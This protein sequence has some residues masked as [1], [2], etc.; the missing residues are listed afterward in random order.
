MNPLGR[1]LTAASRGADDLRATTW[2][3][4]SLDDWAQMFTDPASV[5]GSRVLET[6]QGQPAE[7]SDGS[8]A[9]MV[10]VAYRR[11]GVVFAVM[12]V[13]MKL[14]SEARFQFQQMNGGKPGDL[15]GTP[16]LAILERPWPKA[17]TGDLLSRMLQDADLA[18]NSYIVRRPRFL[19]R[20][21]PDWCAL[22]LGSTERPDIDP[23]A[24]D[25]ELVGLMYVPGGFDSD[26]EPDFFLPEE[27][28][29]FA[30]IPD[31]LAHYRGMSWIT[32]IIRE[33][34]ADGAA[35][36][37]KLKFFENG[38]TPNLVVSLD[39]KIDA[40]KFKDWVR[41]F[42][43]KHEGVRNAY[44]TL[45]LGAGAT[46]VPVGKDL[47]QLEFKVT[48]GAGETRIAAA[49]GVPPVI[50]G[51]SEG[52]AAATYSN[53]GQARRAL[54]DTTMSNLW[55]NA[56]GSLESIVKLPRENGT[57]RLWYDKAGIPFLA[58][59]QK[60]AAA[61]QAQQAQSIKSLVDAG[62]EPDAVIAAVTAG[63]LGLL[64]KKHSG[65]YSV[66]LQAPGDGTD[67]SQTAAAQAGRSLAALIAPHLVNPPQLTPG[68]Q[69]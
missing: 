44:R 54:G 53:Y 66:Q 31:P 16:E 46:V 59:D 35:T 45:Y 67:P 26:H 24:V 60:D 64:K 63:D 38:A 28:A 52:L 11:N 6:F 50:V 30:P 41:L 17:T 62:F 65:L 57:V 21:R 23:D 8:F 61:V 32:P 56:A 68:G 49:G 33:V 12:L 40:A 3:A 27:F 69:S 13:R 14:F 1:L 7:L 48:Q 4:L 18:G 25:A 15:F 43:E 55:R 20:L 42:K 19:R 10:N 29:H 37:H 34:A 58:D 36:T 39:P 22:I 2:P 5:Y 51:L 47:Q 9:S